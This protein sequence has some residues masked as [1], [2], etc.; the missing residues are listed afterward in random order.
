MSPPSR[1]ET[2]A[3]GCSCWLLLLAAGP[4]SGWPSC[5][6]GWIASALCTLLWRDSSM[7][8]TPWRGATWLSAAV[9]R[10]ECKWAQSRPFGGAGVFVG[11]RAAPAGGSCAH[12]LVTPGTSHHLHCTFCCTCTSYSFRCFS[13]CFTY[14]HVYTALLLLPPPTHLHSRL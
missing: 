6:G 4:A 2:F 10:L 11:W 5:M 1:V 3:A 8:P 13:V 9:V 12:T 14:L 7:G